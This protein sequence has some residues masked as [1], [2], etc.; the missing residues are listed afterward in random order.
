MI[1]LS[2][3]DF[4]QRFGQQKTLTFITVFILGNNSILER[5][6][7]GI[8]VDQTKIIRKKLI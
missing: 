8:Y 3:K 6:V 1:F 7:L 5:R 2:L 4:Y